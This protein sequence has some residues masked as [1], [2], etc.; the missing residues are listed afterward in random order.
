MC[1]G[2]M[3]APRRLEA[4]TA[5]PQA[6]PNPGIPC[7]CEASPGKGECAARPF[8]ASPDCQPDSGVTFGVRGSTYRG[9]KGFSCFHQNNACEMG[10]LRDAERRN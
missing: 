9:F 4:S 5:L 3:L 6:E 8:L 1:N 7:S 10:E 2:P